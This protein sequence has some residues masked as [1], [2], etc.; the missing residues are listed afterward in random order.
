MDRQEQKISTCG[1]A[2]I[3]TAIRFL[4]EEYKWSSFR[5]YIGQGVFPELVMS[6]RLIVDVGGREEYREFV[7]EWLYDGVS[8]GYRETIT[9]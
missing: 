1:V 7:Y 3:R 4:E 2:D 8:E 6:D 9:A 5:D